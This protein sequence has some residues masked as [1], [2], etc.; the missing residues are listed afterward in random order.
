MNLNDASPVE[1]LYEYPHDSRIEAMNGSDSLEGIQKKC[2]FCLIT[3]RKQNCGLC[4]LDCKDQFTLLSETS[5]AIQR[6]ISVKLNIHWIRSDYLI[7]ITL[8]FDYLP[9]PFSVRNNR[10]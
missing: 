6:I 3:L 5:Y 8:P 10:S 2:C 1:L 4:Y 9:V 7:Q